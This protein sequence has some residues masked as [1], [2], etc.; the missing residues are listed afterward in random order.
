[1]TAPR[2]PPE[3]T[4]RVHAVGAQTRELAVG[5][6]LAALERRR[7]NHVGV[8]SAAAG[9]GFGTHGWVHAQLLCCVAGVGRVQVNGRWVELRAGHA[10]LQ[11][12]GVPHAYEAV[13]G[14]RWRLCWVIFE[15]D[16]PRQPAIAGDAASVV[17]VD[18]RM[19]YRAIDWLYREVIGHGPGVVADALAELIAHEARRIVA[20]ERTPARRMQ[21]VWEAVD[22]D[23]TRPWQVED[24][25]SMLDVTPDH[26][27]RLCRAAFARSP[28]EQL[29]H[30]RVRRAFSLLSMTDMK[31]DAVASAVGYADRFSFSTAFRRVTGQT[32]AAFRRGE[33]TRGSDPRGTSTGASTRSTHP[34]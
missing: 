4:R 8:S 10:Y 2:R 1:V 16:R 22:A 34:V 14:H 9:F 11:P 21:H 13:A 32:P 24:L 33:R 28:G 29:A 27:R 3:T 20:E 25:A 26:F 31:I 5:A 30:L 7:I 15:R 19:L 17:R 23:L 12:A 6:P 18:G